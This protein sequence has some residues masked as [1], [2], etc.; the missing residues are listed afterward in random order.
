MTNS[1]KK[2][3]R[4][5]SWGR[6]ACVAVGLGISLSLSGCNDL[7]EV[8]LPAQL[9]NEVLADP[10]G[11]GIQLNTVIGNFEEA[12]NGYLWEIFG[13]EGGG[14]I[15]LASAGTT[16]AAFRYGHSADWFNQISR[17]RNF[18]VSLHEK[19]DKEW[20]VKDVPLRSQYLAIT[21]LYAGAVTSWM[22]STLCEVSLDAGPLLTIDKTYA[23]AETLLTRA[24]AEIG[25][26]GGDFAMPFGISTS[27][28]TMAYGLR[29]QL[30]WMKGDNAG[31]LAD[32][33]KVPQGFNAWVTR[34]ATPARRNLAFYNGN[35]L[36]YLELYDP[37]DWW[38]GPANPANN[39]LWP[40][41]I[42]FTGYPNLGILPDGR[43]VRDDGL[44]IR[45]AG[46]YR[47]AIESTAVADTRVKTELKQVQAKGA[48]GYVPMR[49]TSEADDFPLVNWKEM[50]L[51]RAELEG[52]Q[53]AIDKVNVL[54]TADGLP[55]VTYAD[56]A[57]ATQ[58]KYMIIEERR[59]AL[60]L[61]GRF[62]FTMLKNP[63]LLWFPRASG[64]AP[65]YGQQLNGGVRFVMPDNEFDLNKNL[66]KADRA[67]NCAVGVKP[68]I[69]GG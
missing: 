16:N 3:V 18:A 24:I 57:N 2:R 1:M 29:A 12:Y 48:L 21:S 39:Q 31:A 66:T 23:E 10:V 14:E 54:R 55:K 35:F 9:T 65:G 26:A 46:N 37:I 62:F 58:I 33:V 6:S 17:S 47:T 41:P 68:V 30:R 59:R 28:M 5:T 44:P 36:R 20:T 60:Y 69:L 4:L 63:D 52:G 64:A 11:A 15:R 61:E 50:W 25:S 45:T 32:A 22:G 27:A 38:I 19:L 34:E 51:I 67:A 13:R 8:D 40:K 53:A 56:P 7:L 42:P 43:A 49:Y